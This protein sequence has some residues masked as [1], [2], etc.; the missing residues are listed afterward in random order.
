MGVGFYLT[1]NDW[2]VGGSEFLLNINGWEWM[3]VG[4]WEWV[5]A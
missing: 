1:K 5:G 2:K 3:G 4:E